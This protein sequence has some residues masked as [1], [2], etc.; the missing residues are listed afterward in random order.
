MS[1]Y[2]FAISQLVAWC[3]LAVGGYVFRESEPGSLLTL[4][5]AFGVGLPLFHALEAREGRHARGD[6]SASSS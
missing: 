1:R 5:L 6:D 3:I 4:I 2:A